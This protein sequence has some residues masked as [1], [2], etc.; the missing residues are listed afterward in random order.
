MKVNIELII[1]LLSEEFK[2]NKMPI[3]DLIEAQTK[4]PFRVLVATILSARTRDEN[5]AKAVYKLFSVIKNYKDFYKLSIN[6]IENLIF[7]VGFYHQKAKYLKKLPL[8]LD[9]K[10][11]GKIPQTI[12]ELIT[13]PGVGRKTANLVLVIA[14]NIPA[15]CVDVHVNRIMNRIGYVKT[16]TPFETEMELRRKLPRKHWLIVNSIFVS[17]GQNLCFPRN[18]KCDVCPIADFCN[19]IF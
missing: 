9:E 8:I 7:G 5:T 14:Y 4:D 19:K 18:P 15:I 3:V 11:D 17:F 12:E 10:F 16:K 6:E 13:L 2:K 1:K